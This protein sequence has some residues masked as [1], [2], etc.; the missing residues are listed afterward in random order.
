MVSNPVSQALPNPPILSN[1]SDA[2]AGFRPALRRFWKGQFTLNDLWLFL[3]PLVLLIVLDLTLI[4]PNDFWWHL[5]T[6]QIIVE[7]KSIPTT[8]LF[9]FTR[10][11]LPW[12]NQSWLM[13]VLFYLLY[14]AG[15]LPLII[16]WH[17]L[18]ISAGYMLVELACLRSNSGQA[19]A[20]ALA[21][22]AAAAIGLANWNVRP[23]SA[24]FLLFGA[25]VFVLETHRVRGGRI[26]WALPP[27]FV[28]WVNL[29]GGF[30]FGIG[31]LGIYVLAG[32]GK[33]WW[34]ERSLRVETR[35]LL[36][37]GVVSVLALS[38]NPA[39]PLGILH[40]VLGFFR[41]HTTQSLNIEFMPLNMRQADGAIFFSVVILLLLI[42]YAR[43][44]TVSP[45]RVVA[46]LVFGAYS[47]YSRRVAPW[48]GMAAA[49]AF[50]AVLTQRL[51]PA[52]VG[53]VPGRGKP[54]FNYVLVGLLGLVVLT[55]LPWLRPYLPL[56]P[57]RR[58]YVTT[59]ET[60][61]QA[62]QVL[63]QHGDKARVFDDIA[64]GSYLIWACPTVP[65]FMDTRFELYPD[66]MWQDY[67]LIIRAQF[68]WEDALAKYGI[69]TIFVRKD[70][71][72]MLVAAAKAS[73]EWQTVY[74]NKHTII[75]QRVVQ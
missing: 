3:P 5:R 11:G 1:I 34:T 73:D 62:T 7:T 65:V 19:R 67:L 55:T 33:D 38:L 35:R 63:C 40:Y 23:Q 24:S 41:N 53:G 8:D 66:E 28:L 54:L 22:I 50:A 59:A 46:M 36:V 10:A 70:Q 42:A 15:G 14:Q 6:G 31:L 13:Q 74:E 51:G 56:S 21:V 27:L 17:A 43:R 72:Q 64:Y 48:F 44:V 68:G 2:L 29:H 47:L 32:W 12:T 20:A 25:L 37:V 39:G 75:L 60:P 52:R 71:E 45:F 4:R 49:P 57:A 16:F 18:T 9:S 58:A 26:L 69:D 61:V 30:V